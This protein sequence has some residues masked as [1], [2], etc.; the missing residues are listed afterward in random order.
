[1]A[2]AYACKPSWGDP[3][4]FERREQPSSPALQ[5]GLL[6]SANHGGI[7]GAQYSQVGQVL[8]FHTWLLEL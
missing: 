5:Q 8:Q 1:M 6:A 7:S 2:R 4:K 3:G